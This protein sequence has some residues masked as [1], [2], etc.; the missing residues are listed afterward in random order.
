MTSR[1]RH[2]FQA[3]QAVLGA[4]DITTPQINLRKRPGMAHIEK[5]SIP[6]ANVD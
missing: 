5:R 3:S 4:D 1:L 2:F 6:M